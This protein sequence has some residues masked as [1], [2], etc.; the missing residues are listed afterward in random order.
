[1]S[2]TSVIDEVARRVWAGRRNLQRIAVSTDR[3]GIEIILSVD[4]H[5]RIMA[6]LAEMEREGR[7]P[8]TPAKRD[9]SAPGGLRFFGMIVRRDPTFLDDEIR[10]RCEVA[11]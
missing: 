7:G 10:F 4:L 6:E 3:D 8:L 1:M 2:H 11:L 5:T 9:H